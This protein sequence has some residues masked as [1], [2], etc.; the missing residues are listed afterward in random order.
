[1]ATANTTAPLP[2]SPISDSDWQ[3]LKA[4]LSQ[5][6]S[7]LDWLDR[8]KKA[9][10]LPDDQIAALYATHNDTFSKAKATY[11]AFKDLHGEK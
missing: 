7:Y 11:N 3:T 1:M 4:L 10:L 5:E 8:T 2:R 6:K 9:G